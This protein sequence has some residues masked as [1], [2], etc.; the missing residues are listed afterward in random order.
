MITLERTLC[1]HI[2]Y[3]TLFIIRSEH[4]KKLLE[5]KSE[6]LAK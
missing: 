1:S 3:K 2:F 4:R 5:K 6:L